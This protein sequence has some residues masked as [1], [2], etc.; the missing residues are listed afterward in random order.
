MKHK[1]LRDAR[2]FFTTAPMPCPY[3]PGLV[4][5]RLVTELAGRDAAAYHDA[6]SRAGFRRSH[7]IAYVPICPDCAACA[8]ARIVAAEA[9]R[10]RSQKRV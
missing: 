10:T 3:L 8:T 6:L 2:F 4:E 9:K 5:R 1:A 7:G